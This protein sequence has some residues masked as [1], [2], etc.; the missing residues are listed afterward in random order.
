MKNKYKIKEKQRDS[1]AKIYYQLFLSNQFPE[2][3]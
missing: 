2:E 1:A 3:S